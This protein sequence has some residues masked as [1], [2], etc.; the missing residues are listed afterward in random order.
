[1]GCGGSADGNWR[2][3]NQNDPDSEKPVVYALR[4]QERAIRDINSAFV[5]F[6]EMISLDVAKQWRK[7]VREAISGLSTHPRRCPLVPER[8][9]GEVRQLLY[10][11]PGSK[12]AYRIVFS[13]T[14]EQMH[15]SDAPTVSILH[16]RH[17]AGRPITRKEAQQL[18]AEI[19][20]DRSSEGT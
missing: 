8:F 4:L 1:M 20:E 2:Q 17:A 6:A 18:E 12:T 3:V 16:V 15:S 10:R 9:Q 7:G 13:I 14:G 11:R 5:R 19:R